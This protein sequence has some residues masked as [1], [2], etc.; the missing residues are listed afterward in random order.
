MR[1]FLF[2]L[3]T[4]GTWLGIGV[5][6]YALFQIGLGVAKKRGPDRAIM[7]LV[8][9]IVLL[10]GGWTLSTGSANRFPIFWAILPFSGWASIVCLLLTFYNAVNLGS[11]KGDEI[12]RHGQLV[13]LYG[14]GA[15]G[16]LWLAYRDPDQTQRFVKGAIPLGTGTLLGVAAVLIGVAFLLGY[17][18]DQARTKKMSRGIVIHIALLL[19]SIVF[20]IPFLFLLSTSFKEDRDMSSANGMIWIP[21]VQ[22]TSEYR[23]PQKPLYETRFEGRRLEAVEIG[24]TEQLVRLDVVR[25]FSLRGTIV[26]VKP[27]DIREIPRQVPLVKAKH[28]GQDIQGQVI[29]DMEDGRKRVLITAP[30]NLAQTQAIFLPNEVKPIRDPGLR[31]QNYTEA[32]EFMPPETQN[33]LMY[34]RN[35]LVIVLMSII[36]TILSSAI[37]AYAFSRMKFPWRDQLFSLL[38]ATMMLPGAVTMMPKFLIFR[39]LGWI[40]TLYPLWVPAFFASAFNVFM[41]RQFFKGIP[42]ELEDAAKID[43]CTY[44]RTFWSVMLPQIKPALSVIFIWTFTAAWNDFQGPLIYINSPENMPLSYALQLFMGERSGEPGLF[45]AFATLTIIPVLALFFLMQR[46]FIE[47]VTLSGFGGR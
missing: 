1:D 8:I 5:L 13:A 42:M 46:Y 6:F 26:E 39:T 24:R 28:Q 7:S 31:W 36:G 43:G 35:T 19:G 22:R 37:V 3:G 16:F 27:N 2:A 23:D 21:K 25:P 4:L 44:L 34:L 17:A 15:A 38:L 14:L 30:R 18:S 45:M 10:V 20:C 11:S 29:E 33:G 9:G 47:G 32:L 40:D 12:R 41:L